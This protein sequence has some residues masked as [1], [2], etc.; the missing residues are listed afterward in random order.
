MLVP[1]CSTIFKAGWGSGRKAKRRNI[2]CTTLV[3]LLGG[4][5]QITG[6]A[7]FTLNSCNRF[8]HYCASLA[9]REE[10]TCRKKSEDGWFAYFS[11]LPIGYTGK[12][13]STYG[14]LKLKLSDDILTAKTLNFVIVTSDNNKWPCYSHSEATL[15]Q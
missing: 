3:D 2:S 4:K 14:M 5:S 15:P 7:W 8:S 10:Y 12:A 13:W 1:T 11:K 6:E 9:E